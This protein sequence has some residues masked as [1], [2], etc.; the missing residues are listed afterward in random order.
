M[1]MTYKDFGNKFSKNMELFIKGSIYLECMEYATHVDA[2]S[3]DL[4][5]NY[6]HEGYLRWLDNP[7]LSPSFIGTALFHLFYEYYE[8]SQD[9]KDMHVDIADVRN[10]VTLFFGITRSM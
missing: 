10:N 4:L 1:K 2:E 8:V 3:K 5:D 6:I 9:L 7:D